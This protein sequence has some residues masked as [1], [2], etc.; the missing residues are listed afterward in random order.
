MR[1]K[2]VDTMMML[3]LIA[4]AMLMASATSAYEVVA[5]KNGG[6]IS[7]TVSVSGSVPEPRRFKVEKTPEVCGADALALQP[8]FGSQRMSVILTMPQPG[9]APRLPAAMM[10]GGPEQHNGNIRAGNTMLIV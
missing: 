10:D 7:G 4:T 6:T 8:C 2:R 3:S 9:D 5:V 1:I